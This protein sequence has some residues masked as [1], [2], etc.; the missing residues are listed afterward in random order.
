VDPGAV[1]SQIDK[2]KEILVEP[3]QLAIL[4]EEGLVGPG[5]TGGY[6][7][8]VQAMFLDLIPDGGETVFRAGIEVSFGMNHVGQCGCVGHYLRNVNGP[9]DIGAAMADKNAY[10][11]R[12]GS[13]P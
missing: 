11:D 4:L 12:H 3:G 5:R 9:A 10:S 8:T 7:N 2:F 6:H 1:L 13:L